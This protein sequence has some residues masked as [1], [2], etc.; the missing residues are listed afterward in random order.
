MEKK[1]SAGYSGSAKDYAAFYRLTLGSWIRIL[2]SYVG[3]GLEGA[4]VNS[5]GM[6]QTCIKIAFT[7]KF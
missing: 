6:Y 7:L 2:L 1:I 4:N 5:K 3:R